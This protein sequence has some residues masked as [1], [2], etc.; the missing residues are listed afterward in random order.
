MGLSIKEILQFRNQTN[1]VGQRLAIEPNSRFGLHKQVGEIKTV[2]TGGRAVVDILNHQPV[3]VKKHE[4]PEQ[5][6]KQKVGRIVVGVD[7]KIFH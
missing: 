2:T 3:R 7:D 4:L 5:V 6:L 1:P